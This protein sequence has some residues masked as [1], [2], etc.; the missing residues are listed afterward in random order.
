M[1]RGRAGLE[2][3]EEPGEVAERRVRGGSGFP[4]AC[5]R[6]P[7]LHPWKNTAQGLA[8][9]RRKEGLLFPHSLTQKGGKK[10]YFRWP[11]SDMSIVCRRRLSLLGTLPL[12]TGTFPSFVPSVAPSKPVQ[13]RHARL[14][15]ALV[16]FRCPPSVDDRRCCDAAAAA[17]G[18]M[19]VS[20]L[21]NGSGVGRRAQAA[22]QAGG[23]RSGQLADEP[24]Q[25]QFPLQHQHHVVPCQNKT[26]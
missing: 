7:F 8:L 6:G 15:S 3:S 2:P 21:H 11:R 24:N 4:T 18:K 16:N 20:C 1:A 26:T 19:V 13:F 14:F 25:A 23:H 22:R 17:S 5:Q 12:W 9:H 10:N